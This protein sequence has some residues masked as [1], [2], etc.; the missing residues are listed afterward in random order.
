MKIIEKLNSKREE[1][2]ERLNNLYHG[3]SQRR[4]TLQYKIKKINDLIAAYQATSPPINLSE[5]N[6]ILDQQVGFEEQKR[7]ILESLEITKFRE[8][9]GIQQTPLILCLIGPTGSGKSTFAQILAQSLKKKF[10]SIALGGIT[11]ASILVGT[12]ESSSGTE[13]GQLAKSLAETKTCDPLILLDEIDK[14]GTSF[15]N[16]IHNCL[17]NTLDPEQNQ[18]VLDHYLDVK[19]DFSQATFVVTANNPQKIPDYLRSRMLI[20][21]LPKYDMKQKKEIAKK[22]VQK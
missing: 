4:E 15:K 2:E 7:E 10:F 22:I 5:A 1:L 14:A 19:L 13:I 16:S 17:I 3:G 6:K 18:A 11:D 9:K 12:S 8:K 21:E 20:I